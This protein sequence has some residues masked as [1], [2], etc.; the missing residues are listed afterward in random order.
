MREEEPRQRA[1][2]DVAETVGG[3]RRGWACFDTSAGADNRE[4]RR[5]WKKL[6]K[7]STPGTVRLLLEGS[8]KGIQDSRLRA[9]A[10]LGTLNTD[11]P[12]SLVSRTSKGKW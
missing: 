11:R 3:V 8:V 1:V 6:G 5:K 9:E 2:G 4:D 7:T 12:R 10:L